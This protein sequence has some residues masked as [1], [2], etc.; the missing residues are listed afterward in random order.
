MNLPDS[1]HDDWT[2]IH[3]QLMTG[4]PKSYSPLGET[5]RIRALSPA[6]ESSSCP[7]VPRKAAPPGVI[8]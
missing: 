4:A 8:G 2:A 7:P 5:P 3:V 1:V 6:L